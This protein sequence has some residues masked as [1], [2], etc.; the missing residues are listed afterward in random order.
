MKILNL[1]F[2][3]LN[4]LVGEWQI[5]FTAAEYES[6]GLFAIIGPTG[7]G[8]TSLLDAICL[9]LYGETP[10]LGRIT[11]S[12]NEILSKSEGECFAEVVFAAGGGVYRS[13]WY[14][15]RS[16]KRSDGK[17][18]GVRWEVSD[19]KSGKILA[20]KIKDCDAL[21]EKLSGMT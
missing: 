20:E 13:Y 18:Q 12:N 10:R 15:Q 3:N 16:R 6:D 19:V 21:I 8:K 9:A 11:A 7:V 2:K 5:D 1:R 4:S 14:Q 17:L